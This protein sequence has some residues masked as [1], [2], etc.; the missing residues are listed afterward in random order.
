MGLTTDTWKDPYKATA[1]GGLGYPVC[2]KPFQTV[3]SD[4]NPSYDGDLPGSPFS[5]AATT[6]NDTPANI[7]G[8][9]AG[10]QGQAIWTH[11]FGGP[12]KRV[13]RRGRW[14]DRWRAHGEDR[15]QL[16]Q[17]P[18]PVARRADQGRH[19][20]RRQRGAFRAHHGHKCGSVPAEA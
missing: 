18:R 17:Y 6:V 14:R 20:L 19:L 11:E 3:I 7:A 5:G 9:N 1:N 4:I 16:R 15:F 12:Q 13:H 8:F 10:T 2:A